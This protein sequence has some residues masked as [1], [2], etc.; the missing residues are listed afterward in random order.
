[1]VE[2]SGAVFKIPLNI[3]MPR[4]SPM[5]QTEIKQISKAFKKLMPK[6]GFFGKK[7]AVRGGKYR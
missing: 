3:P 5:M 7:Y 6:S 2:M 4:Q 1:M